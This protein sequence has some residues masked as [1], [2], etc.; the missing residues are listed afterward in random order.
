MPLIAGDQPQREDVYIKNTYE[1]TDGSNIQQH[2]QSTKGDIITEE[3]I[4]STEHIPKI[5]QGM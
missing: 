2:G 5:D 4:Q 1:Q 3:Q